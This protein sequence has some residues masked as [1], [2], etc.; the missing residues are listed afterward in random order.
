MYHT[1][2]PS[3]IEEEKGIEV[4]QEAGESIFVWF[5]CSFYF[6]FLIII[7]RYQVGGIISCATWYSINNVPL[8]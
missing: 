5:N 6:S 4:I 8:F 7:N 3:E 1:T 2:L